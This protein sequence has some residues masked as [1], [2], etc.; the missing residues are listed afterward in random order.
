MTAACLLVRRQVYEEVGGLDERL[1]V[2]FNDIDFCLRLVERGY[3][4]L[5][6]PDAEL[7][8][9]ESASRGLEDNPEKL[10]RFM[11]EI[12]HMQQRWGA[13]LAHDPAYNPNLSLEG[14]PF[15]LAWSRARGP[16]VAGP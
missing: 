4:N 10:A 14:A 9:H 2:A 3:R 12:R 11:S 15:T 7:Y 13:A 8:H 5:W 1:K 16:S 6:T